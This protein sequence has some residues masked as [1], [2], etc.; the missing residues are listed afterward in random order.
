MGVVLKNR[1]GFNLFC[2]LIFMGRYIDPKCKLCRREGAKLF[3]KGERCHS[4]KCALVKRK[5]AP[6][7]HGPSKGTRGPRLTEFGQQLRAKQSA[8]RIY[9]L[10]EKQFS[11]Y[12]QEAVRQ[13][14]DTGENLLALLESRIDN[15]IYRVGWSSSRDMG[16]QMVNHSLITVNDK[17]V[18]IPSFHVKAG[19]VIKFKDIK[20]NKTLVKNIKEQ[21]LP[22]DIPSWLE[23]NN[24][25]GRIKILGTPTKEDITETIDDKLIVEFYSRK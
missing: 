12:Y 17:K 9:G 18:D 14:G 8:K 6:G 4:G 21:K 16:R 2:L 25:E 5:Y 10:M 11:N 22:K 3:L 15:V 19:D 24:Q 23:I 1:E 20:K 13:K 7:V